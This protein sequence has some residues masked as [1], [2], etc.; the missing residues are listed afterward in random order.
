[1]DETFETEDSF[2]KEIAKE[3]AKAVAVSIVGNAAGIALFLGLGF[4]A[5]K[6]QDRKARKENN[7]QEN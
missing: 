7:N 3:V 2:G 5:K 4:A 6:I 1:M